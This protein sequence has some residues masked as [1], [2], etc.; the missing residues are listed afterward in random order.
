MYAFSP[1][2][3]FREWLEVLDFSVI[4][5]ALLANIIVATI[6]AQKA[7]EQAAVALVLFT[8]SLRVFRLIRLAVQGTM[9][10]VT[11]PTN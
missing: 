3:F 2:V 6:K 1:S 7:G 8:R 5:I 4:T 10:S 9:H 11:H